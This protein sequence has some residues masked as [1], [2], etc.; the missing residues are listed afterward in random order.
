MGEC[1]NEHSHSQVNSHFRSWSP[2]GLLNFLDSDCRGQNPSHWRIL[3]II[4]KILKLRCLK[5][6][7]MTHLNI[8]NTSYGQK[9]GRE[10]N[11]QFD[12]RPLKVENCPDFPCVQVACD[13]PLEKS[14]QGLQLCFR[15]HLDQRSAHKVIAPQ[16]CGSSNFGNFGTPIWES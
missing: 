1:E 13:T 9:K 5:W 11:W 8:S 4:G 3:Y 15:P 2:G 10:S 14:W 16:S 6:A 12:S 7:R